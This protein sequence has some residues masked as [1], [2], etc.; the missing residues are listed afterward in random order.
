MSQFAAYPSS[1]DE[2]GRIRPARVV[3]PVATVLIVAV[4]VLDVLTLVG[5]WITTAPDSESLDEL[6]VLSVLVSLVAAV[7]FLNWV[8][9]VRIN[10]ELLGG[11]ESQ[12]HNQSTSLGGWICPG[13]NLWFPYQIMADIYRAS[14][15]RG[16]VR[17]RIIGW[18][19][20]AFLSSELI[21]DVAVRAVRG[22]GN[23][24]LDVS[25]TVLAMQTVAQVLQIAAAVLIVMVIRQI[26]AWQS[27]ASVSPLVA[28]A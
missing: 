16:P 20:A 17:A 13:L 9:K 6:T 12:R 18:W 14:A 1:H 28:P 19:W 27:T 15:V 5:N 11:P 22:L 7:A 23:A 10:A 2:D 24:T 4:T 25:G 26:N 21:D 8:W 3:G